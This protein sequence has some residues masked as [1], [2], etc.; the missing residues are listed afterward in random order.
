MGNNKS[1]ML[2][3]MT[4]DG[5]ARIFVLNSK[6]MVESMRASHN[7]S[8]TVSPSSG[9]IVPIIEAAVIVLPRAAV[10]VGEVL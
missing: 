2:R 6:N 4:R 3:A 5:S 9:S 8:P 10:T 7:T 1:T